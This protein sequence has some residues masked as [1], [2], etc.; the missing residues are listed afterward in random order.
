MVGNLLRV[1]DCED[2]VVTEDCCGSELP[3]ER[4]LEDSAASA[5]LACCN[6]RSPRGTDQCVRMESSRGLD[7]P[8]GRGFEG[9]AGL[10]VSFVC[11]SPR[12][13]DCKG[14]VVFWSCLMGNLP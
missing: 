13:R 2:N 14:K 1:S 8:R 6:L 7:L 3:R 10:V 4:D 9:N 12:R 5:S 11:E